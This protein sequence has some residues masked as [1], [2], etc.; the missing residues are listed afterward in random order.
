MLKTQT[1]NMLLVAGS[2]LF[3]QSVQAADEYSPGYQY[4]MRGDVVRDAAGNCLRTAQWSPS[5]AL[6]MCDPNVVAQRSSEK[7]VIGRPR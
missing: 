2:L 5:N 4:D 3:A 6:A 1:R 7:P